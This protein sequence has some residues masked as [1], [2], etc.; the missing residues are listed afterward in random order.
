M[1]DFAEK[2]SYTLD[3]LKDLLNKADQSAGDRVRTE[4]SK[5][6]KDL[7]AELD[8]YKPTEPTEAEKA[9]TEREK[10]LAAKEKAFACKA[11]GIPEAYADYFTEKADFGKLGELF[12]AGAGYVP[13]EH[14]SGSSLTKEDFAQ[15]DYAQ[16]AALYEQNRELY[17]Q[18]IK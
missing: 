17:N 15:M 11:A 16:R 13:S 6:V 18:L 3:E 14:K 9:L 8:K 4:Y 1:I 2:D 7:Q 5:R 10:A 12:K